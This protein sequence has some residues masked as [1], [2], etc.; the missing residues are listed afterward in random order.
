[1]LDI[2]ALST[3]ATTGGNIGLTAVKVGEVLQHDC[4]VTKHSATNSGYSREEHIAKKDEDHDDED[5]FQVPENYEIFQTT[6]S[7]DISSSYSRQTA[8]R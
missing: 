6:F 2:P 4:M 3:K 5:Y 7:L 8:Y 1:M